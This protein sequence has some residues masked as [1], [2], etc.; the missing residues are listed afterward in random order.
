[1]VDKSENIF[2]TMLSNRG[3]DSD[4]DPFSKKIVK[5]FEKFS[6]TYKQAFGRGITSEVLKKVE[7]PEGLDFYYRPY[8]DG[9][10]IGLLRNPGNKNTLKYFL[11]QTTNCQNNDQLFVNEIIEYFERENER[12]KEKMFFINRGRTKWG[13]VQLTKYNRNLAVQI[14]NEALIDM[15][16][17]Y[18]IVARPAKVLKNK[19][20]PIEENNYLPTRIDCERAAKKLLGSNSK[21]EIDLLELLDKIEDDLEK[22][23]RTLANDWR[24]I[25]EKKLNIWFK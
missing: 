9:R 5:T 21:D 19:V 23:G 16:I 6:C 25:T 24:L 7:I 13:T 4:I 17:K 11:G 2:L 22:S 14:I 10:V 18:G 3:Q 12:K 8:N 15:A 20:E 1:M